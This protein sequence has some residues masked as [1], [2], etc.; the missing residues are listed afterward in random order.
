MRSL[1]VA[2]VTCVPKPPVAKFMKGR[3]PTRP[4]STAAVA[5]ET[6]SRKAPSGSRGMRHAWARSLAV[7][8]GKMAKGVADWES[9]AASIRPATTSLTVPSPPPAMTTSAPPQRP[10]SSEARGVARL[11]G[12]AHLDRMALFA[13]RL[14]RGAHIAARGGFAVQH[15]AGVTG[16]HR[17]SL[18]RIRGTGRRRHR[19]YP[20]RPQARWA[21]SR[22][23]RAQARSPAAW[24]IAR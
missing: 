11:P 19:S 15:Q 22:P 5:P 20:K 4:T 12:H 2:T 1:G 13:N 14:D 3:P 7:P 8:S 10:L 24:P 6:A 18:T 16:S 9:P 23:A 17:H 21:P